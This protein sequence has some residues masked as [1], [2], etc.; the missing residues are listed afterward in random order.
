MFNPC[1]RIHVL[2]P[3]KSPLCLRN[4]HTSKFISSH[5]LSCVSS[6]PSDPLRGHEHHGFL[7]LKL[8]LAW[9]G[10]GGFCLFQ[11]WWL[12]RTAAFEWEGRMHSGLT[13]FPL[14][15]CLSG[16]GCQLSPRLTGSV[17]QSGNF[18]PIPPSTPYQQRPCA[19]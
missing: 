18:R 4:L 10:L 9:R 3:W 11:A 13:D 12:P 14:P 15:M 17:L 16:P 1:L 8:Y 19:C 6:Y 5:I 2:C 7:F